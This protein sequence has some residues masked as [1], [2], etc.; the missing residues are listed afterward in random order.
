MTTESNTVKVIIADDEKVI[1]DTLTTILRQ[2]GFD[3]IGVYSGEE[4]LSV[5]ETFKPNLL[6]T[7]VI[8]NGMNGIETAIEIQKYRPGCRVLLFS[9]QASTS[10][11]LEKARAEGYAFE[12]LTKPVHPRDLLDRIRANAERATV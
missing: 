12:L 10:D 11:L 2:S 5:A 6:I 4:A 7:D 3:A 1:A 8:M 9:G